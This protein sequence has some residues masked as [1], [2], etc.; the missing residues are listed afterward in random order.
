MALTWKRIAYAGVN[1]DITSM[2]GLDDGG[3][4]NAKVA[5]SGPLTV[6]ADSAA[7]AALSPAVGDS[8]FQTDE[9]ATYVCVSI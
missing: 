3:I 4:P 9:T 1:S 6:V 7:K 8:A 2:T 5:N